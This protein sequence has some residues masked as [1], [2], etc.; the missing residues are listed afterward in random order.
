L[1]GENHFHNWAR[2]RWYWDSRHTARSEQARWGIT[3]AEL[4]AVTGPHGDRRLVALEADWRAGKLTATNRIVLCTGLQDRGR[5]EDALRLCNVEYPAELTR[6]LNRETFR[7]PGGCDQVNAKTTDARA[8]KL[9]RALW[10]SAPWRFAQ[11]L[12]DEQERLDAWKQERSGRP[13]KVPQPRLF[14]LPGAKQSRKPGLMLLGD[15]RGPRLAFVFT[16]S[17]VVLPETAW[18]RPV[19]LDVGRWSP[20]V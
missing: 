6:I 16:A 8:A 7:L 9:R 10:E 19:E 17:N 13:R 18:K 15:T 3:A 11:A 4:R 12:A 14:I 20:S 1:I 2:T 5:F